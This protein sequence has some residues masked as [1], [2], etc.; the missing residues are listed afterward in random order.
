MDTKITKINITDYSKENFYTKNNDNIQFN[1]LHILSKEDSD[2][3]S[4]IV[5]A[6]L[7]D[8]AAGHIILNYIS[9]ESKINKFNTVFDYFIYKKLPLKIQNEKNT[10]QFLNSVNNYLKSTYSTI[11]ELVDFVDKQFNTEYQKLLSFY[12]NKP[13]PEILTVYS[14]KDLHYRNFNSF[15]AE[16]TTRNNVNF[17]NLG[18]SN[19]LYNVA[20]I[21]LKE[22]NMDLYSSNNQT[23]DGKR[24]WNSLLKNKNFIHMSDI[25]LNTLTTNRQELMAQKRNKITVKN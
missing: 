23:N 1:I 25:Y 9:M 2:F 15:P 3:S 12:L 19:A 7:N 17:Q 21:I 11:D 5:Q 13:T 24:M 22:L 20:A 4:L 16:K 6:F 14:D 18:I 10:P 8:E